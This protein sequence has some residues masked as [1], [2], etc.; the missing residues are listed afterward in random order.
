MYFVIAN[1]T[2]YKALYWNKTGF[3][4]CYKRLEKS[5]F[6][7]PRKLNGRVLNLSPQQWQWLYAA[8]QELS[9]PI[10]NKLK[11]WLDKSALSVNNQSLLGKAI[12]YTLGQWSNSR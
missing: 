4:L 10:M 11:D 2:K 5:K 9:L 1:A 3:F 8:R 6:K 7:W 12:H